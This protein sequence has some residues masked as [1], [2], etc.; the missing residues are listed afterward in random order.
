MFDPNNPLERAFN[1][2]EGRR[3]TKRGNEAFRHY[4]TLG[5]GR[6][7]E[8]LLKLYT[9]LPLE[10]HQDEAQPP[11]APLTTSLDTL[12][13]WSMKFQWV[14]RADA[15][16]RLQAAQ[17]Q[18]VYET[19]RQRILE[20]GL[21]QTHE[22]LD[23]LYAIFDRLYEDFQAEENVWMHEDKGIGSGENFTV[24]DT[25]RFNAALVT[26]IRNTLADIAAEVGGRP[27]K[28]E[29]TGKGGGPIRSTT[30]ERDL[31]KLSSEDLEALEQLLEKASP[32]DEEPAN[33]GGSAG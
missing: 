24:I 28:T 31:K 23:K 1:E 21:A 7:L 30:I 27:R 14:A 11:L 32:D 22:R 15:W 19:R 13:M 25:V 8:K 10:T 5:P 18:A 2:R 12:K 6:S 16:D 20:T 9:S 33:T 4:A 3:E 29:L 26:E 17:A